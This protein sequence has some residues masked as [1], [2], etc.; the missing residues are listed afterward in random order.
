MVVPMRAWI[1]FAVY[2]AL[3]VWHMPH[4]RSDVAVWRQALAV[5]PSSA[6]A[7]LN[8]L[9]ACAERPCEP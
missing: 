4:W 1:V 2:L 9:K 7:A 3:G 6:R 8:L 5:S